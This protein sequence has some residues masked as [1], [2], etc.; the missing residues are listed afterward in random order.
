MSKRLRW[1]SPPTTS[2]WPSIGI[3]SAGT[4]QQV[5]AQN[6]NITA[7]TGELP[8]AWAD[9]CPRA[10][11][12]QN[13][14]PPLDNPDVRWAISYLI[15]RDAIVAACL[16]RHHGSGRGHLAELRRESRRIWIPS[17]ISTRSIPVDLRS[18]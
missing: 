2:M 13:G 16:R 5:A 18:R 1:R 14:H 17:R 12:I 8:Y 10:L 7:W 6:P 11:M 3:L 4:F 15:D 9:P